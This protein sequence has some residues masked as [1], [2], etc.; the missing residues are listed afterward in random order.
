MN[1]QPTVEDAAS[2]NA[3]LSDDQLALYRSRLESGYYRSPA[4]VNH[5]AERLTDEYYPPEAE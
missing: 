2:D 4:V 5:I 1:A 3:P